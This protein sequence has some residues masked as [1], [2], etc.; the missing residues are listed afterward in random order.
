MKKNYLWML[1]A[2]LTLSGMN[3]VMA[4]EA[5]PAIITPLTR[6]TFP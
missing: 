5:D 1:T 2:I 4:Q 3:D 6:T